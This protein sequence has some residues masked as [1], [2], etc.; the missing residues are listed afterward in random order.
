MRKLYTTLLVVMACFLTGTAFAQPTNVTVSDTTPCAGDTVTISWDL[1]NGPFT[2]RLGT[3]GQGS[4]NITSG[5]VIPNIFKFK[6]SADSTYYFEV[7]DNSSPIYVA[8]PVIAV[9]KKPIAPTGFTIAGDTVSK[10]CSGSGFALDV[11]GGNIGPNATAQWYNAFDDSPANSGAPWAHPALMADTT[12]YVFF[13]DAV[14]NLISDDSLEVSISLYVSPTGNITDVLVDGNP[15]G[16]FVCPGSHTLGLAGTLVG[17]DHPDTDTL[18]STS[19]IFADTMANPFNFQADTAYA[20]YVRVTDGCGGAPIDGMTNPY[21][22]TVVGASS[23]DTL[24]ALNDTV[25]SYDSTVVKAMGYTLASMSSYFMYSLDSTNYIALA[26]GVDS[27]VVNPVGSSRRIFFTVVDSCGGTGDTIFA[28]I[29]V[30]APNVG[31]D[32]VLTSDTAV[33]AGTIVNFTATTY[34]I[35]PGSTLSYSA[36]GGATWIPNMTNPTIGITMT[37]D[38][39]VM[40]RINGLCDTLTSTASYKVTVKTANDEPDSLVA[41]P[42]SVCSGVQVDFQ[43][44]AYVKSNAVVNPSRF[45]FSNSASFTTILQDSSAD[46]FTTIVNADTI[47]YVRMVGGCAPDSTVVSDTVAVVIATVDPDSITA[48]LAGPVILAQ[49]AEVCS[50]STVTLRQINGVLGTDTAMWEYGYISGGMFNSIVITDEDSLEV[51]NITTDT[52][53]AVRRVDGCAGPLPS[54]SITFTI[55][56]AEDNVPTTALGFTAV[57]DANAP[58]ASGDFLCTA[59]TV[60]YTIDGT[61]GDS[62]YYEWIVN[63]DGAANDTL[64]QDTSHT[65]VASLNGLSVNDSL[66]VSVHIVG[67]CTNLAGTF[68][69]H[70]VN[71]I[72]ASSGFIALSKSDD[73]ICA[74]SGDS[75]TLTATGGAGAGNVVWYKMSQFG[76]PV[77]APLKSTA[78][79][80]PGSKTFTEVPTQTTT[81][82][83]RIEGCDT[84]AFIAETVFIRDTSNVPTSISISPNDT[85]CVNSTV[86]LSAQGGHA[87]TGGVYVWFDAGTGDT[88]G[89]GNPIFTNVFNDMSVTVKIAGFCNSTP[90]SDTLDIKTY[91]TDD[92]VVTYDTVS[93]CPGVTVDLD[94][95][96]TPNTGVFS[97]T[98]VTG[99]LFNSNVVGPHTITFTKTFLGGCQ[100]SNTFVIVVNPAPTIDSTYALAP[101][102]CVGNDGAFTI[103]ASGATAPYEYSAN[104]GGVYQISNVFTGQNAGNK[105]LRVKD[106]NGCVSDQGQVTVAS[107]SGLNIDTTYHE[108]IACFGDVNG[109]SITVIADSGLAPYVYAIR[110][111]LPIAG[112]FGNDTT[113][114]VFTGLG[115]GTYE[116]RVTDSNSPGCTVTQQVVIDAPTDELDLTVVNYTDPTCFYAQDGKIDSL[117]ASGGT[118]PYTYS[119]DG[120]NF[121]S[122]PSFSDMAGGP[123]TIT[124]KDAAGCTAPF[125]FSLTSPDTI[126]A[127]IVP[128]TFDM[129]TNTWTIDV[130]MTGGTG[131][132]QI[133]LNAMPYTTETTIDSVLAGDYNYTVKDANGCTIQGSFHLT[134]NGIEDGKVSKSVSFSAYP[135]PFSGSL[136]VAGELAEGTEIVLIDIYGKQIKANV[137][138]DG[139]KAFINTDGLAAGMYI[140]NISGNGVNFSKKVIKE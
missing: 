51:M 12:Y 133:K 140:L 115:A 22:V 78:I 105:L 80:T 137:T 45:Q 28:D 63:V 117:Y 128:A 39:A 4:T 60:T 69:T 71:V 2:I 73:N 54:D 58:V 132:L 34:T 124:V 86:S 50:G 31:I 49:G 10:V 36:D 3:L 5:P 103:A 64:Q 94:S 77:G 123:Y 127:E 17:G 41:T 106:A 120:V 109:G 66:V 74:N 83:V 100:I 43:A 15:S 8:T 134:G 104:N 68:R 42:N 102:S 130:N 67:G 107:T 61:L 81:Y 135:N 18:F 138:K 25:C 7:R 110:T 65:F 76:Q 88:L 29:T 48:E 72:G 136:V 52:V 112:A 70:T 16:T 82:G 9:V 13:E 129:N 20:I 47:I 11:F 113:S 27:I 85:V 101:A 32:T 44:A 118:G 35:Q 59:D 97:G 57:N 91:G 26:P 79:A 139:D 37:Q 53:F 87:G 116:V 21:T 119:I 98:G 114:N 125:S 89:M 33:C 121:Q 24:V 96:I 1:A 122:T 23:L 55:G 108:D 56:V 6:V 19:P 111:V 126:T 84:T 46:N 30:F 93:V 92:L 95:M 90:N 99:D 62:A 38:T 14:C 75:V 40:F 131:V